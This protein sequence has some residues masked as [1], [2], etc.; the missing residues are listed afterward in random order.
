[1][2]NKDFNI[3]ILI[4]IA[5]FPFVFGCTPKIK[6]LLGQLPEPQNQITIHQI[7]KYPR[8]ERIEREISTF[9]G[10]TI[11]ININSFLHSNS[12]KKIELVPR[13]PNGKYYDL[14]L[15]LNRKGRLHWMSLSNGFKGEKVAFVIDGIFYRS[16]TPNQMVGDYDTDDGSTYVLIEGPFDKGTADTLVEWAPK[17]YQF[18]HDEDDEF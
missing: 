3:H 2:T 13:G 5:V 16:F 4:L 18:Y 12:I 15:F 7:V 17:N 6:R 1:M 11:C 14:K 9:S 10:R 8:A